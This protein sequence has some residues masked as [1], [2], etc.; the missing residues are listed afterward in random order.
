ML[1]AEC[2]DSVLAQTNPNWECIVVDDGSID[3]TWEVLEG[4]QTKD[5]RIRIFKRDREPKGAPTCRNIGAELSYG[6]Y[7]LFF[8]SD[9]LLFPWCLS[10]VINSINSYPEKEMLAFQQICYDSSK[11]KNQFWERCVEDNPEGYIKRYITFQKA[12]STSSIVWHKNSFF[13]TCG[14]DESLKSWQDPPL[15]L[16]AFFK[17]LE[18][19]WISDNATS[20]IRTNS[21]DNNITQTAVIKHFIGALK[22]VESLISDKN[23]L[24]LKKSIKSLVWKQ[25]LFCNDMNEFKVSLKEICIYNLINKMDVII[26]KLYFAIYFKTKKIKFVKHFVYK[27]SF[28]FVKHIK[29][30]EY[31][32]IE[33]IENS[34]I[35][36]SYYSLPYSNQELFKSLFP[37]IRI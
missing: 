3:N 6:N 34:S 37:F 9:D 29:K 36:S 21:A 5:E 18:F 32:Y 8:D 27:C 22:K 15:I 35:A 14:W 31:N 25:F 10:T 26:I 20:L 16:D 13:K 7:I 24:V 4:Y 33:K 28:L 1:V 17:Q 23:K 30:F 12:L 2:L 19:K 11:E